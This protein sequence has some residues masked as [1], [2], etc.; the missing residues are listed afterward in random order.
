MSQSI[1]QAGTCSPHLAVGAF[2][3]AAGGLS[4]SSP[5]L[6]MDPNCIA[7]P[8]SFQATGTLVD[9][10]Y[11]AVASVHLFLA[12]LAPQLGPSGWQSE[13]L[14]NQVSCKRHHTDA[15]VAALDLVGSSSPEDLPALFSWLAS[16]VGEIDFL[17]WCVCAFNET[18]A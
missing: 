18:L 1:S 12:H 4:P 8:G 2:V 11:P 16:Q 3:P 5:W 7:R 6:S 14:E 17:V 13:C 9:Q 15:E 10:T